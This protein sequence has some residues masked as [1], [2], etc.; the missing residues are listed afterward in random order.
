M[1]ASIP[2]F[3]IFGATVPEFGFGP[4]GPKAQIIENRHL[5]CRPC[6]IHGSKN[7]PMKTF[8]CMQS[9]K[10]EMVTEKIMEYYKN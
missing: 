10:P 7:C 1:V 6:G 9:I 2:V 5:T 8:D 3:A 4:F